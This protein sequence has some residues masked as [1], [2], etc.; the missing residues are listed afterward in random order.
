MKFL[1]TGA[2]GFLG[3]YIVERL[4]AEGK[5]VRA[6][7]RRS[8]AALERPEIEVFI[9]DLRSAESC[10]AACCGIDA[11]FH[12]AALT[13]IGMNRRP[14]YETNVV[15]TE[16]ILAGCVAEG[17]RRLVYT[18]SPSVTD[19]GRP[20][21]GV[22]ESTPYPK[23]YLAYY[24]ETKALA[25]RR[26]LTANS[27][28]LTSGGQ[29]STCSLRPRL[30]WGPRDRNLIPRLISLARR[31]RLCRVGDGTNRLDMIYIENAVDA[32]L[33]AM[34]NLAAESPVAG[35]AYYLSQGD[36]VNC[37]EFIDRVLAMVGLGPVR[38]HISFRTAW[39][40]GACCEF[41]YRLLRIEKEPLMTRF[42]AT[43]LA[44]SYWFNTTKAK[45][46][47]GFEPA[48]STQ[49]GLR[50]LEVYLKKECEFE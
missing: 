6:F 40:V 19:N 41:F 24:P 36:P 10:R 26:V 31:G 50:R 17:V 13:G 30:I 7:C 23:K 48:V 45:K 14:F 46:D 43:Q 42:L 21:E 47:F 25:E 27:T 22:D 18:G 33:L 38:R 29:L 3:Q 5:A 15:G 35:S 9:G 49:E 8:S 11:V 20:Q 1:V 37:W 4:A 28:P 34:K 44:Q 12:T 2:T 32:H 39:N 16:N